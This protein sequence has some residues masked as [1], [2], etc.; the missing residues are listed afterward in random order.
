MQWKWTFD[1]ATGGGGGE[2]EAG[3]GKD[4]P[5][6]PDCDDRSK[7]DESATMVRDVL[8]RVASSVQRAFRQC[9]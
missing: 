8:Q 9:G 1:S 2:A 4:R 3:E 5:A 7:P 6:S